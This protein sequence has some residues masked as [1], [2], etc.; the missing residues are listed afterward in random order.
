MREFQPGH[1][2]APITINTGPVDRFLAQEDEMP[3]YNDSY[4]LEEDW[5]RLRLLRADVLR[6]RSQLRAKRRELHEKETAKSLA[7]DLFMKFVRE[8]RPAKTPKVAL[9]HPTSSSLS[10]LDADTYY[11][12]LQATRDEYGPLQY[13]YSILEDKLDAEEFEL[14][15]IEGRLYNTKI[16]DFQDSAPDLL[17]S[18]AL[19]PPPQP[20]ESLLGLSSDATRDY[21]PLHTNYL[22]RLGDLDLVREQYQNLLEDRQQL[23]D[24]QESRTHLGIELQEDD[25]VFLAD[26]HIQEKELAGQM[27]EIEEDVERRKAQCL[28][29]GILIDTSHSSNSFQN[30]DDQDEQIF[31]GAEE[32][33]VLHGYSDIPIDTLASMC[34]ILL[35]ESP[36]GRKDLGWLITDFDEANKSDRINRWILFQ[37]QTSPIEVELLVRISLHILQLLGLYQWQRNVLSWWSLDSANKPPEAFNNPETYTPT[38]EDLELQPDHPAKEIKTII[39][40]DFTN[41]PHRRTRSCPCFQDQRLKRRGLVSSKS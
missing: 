35:P 5:K 31:P 22:S 11:S 15:T 33:I 1:Q 37:L 17:S 20:P 34:S 38:N 3:D 18:D 25:K 19:P 12:K 24:L 36:E 23:L 16:H 10:E 29:E 28:A 26:F 39:R 30:D 6:L 21:H 8:N 32:E 14:A 27:K 7:D 41:V 40:R 13:E 2:N 4:Q 9:H